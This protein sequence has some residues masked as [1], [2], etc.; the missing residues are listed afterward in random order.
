ML[1]GDGAGHGYRVLRLVSTVTHAWFGGDEPELEDKFRVDRSCCP[2]TLCSPT[3]SIKCLPTGLYIRTLANQKHTRGRFVDVRTAAMS[4][5]NTPGPHNK[6][7]GTRFSHSVPSLLMCVRIVRDRHRCI[8]T[9]SAGPDLAG[10]PPLHPGASLRLPSTLVRPLP[11]YHPPL[12][13]A[14]HDGHHV[15]QVFSQMP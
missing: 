15:R 5:S 1:G 12:H 7:P 11:R 2:N 9:H 3:P 13:I 8:T 4:D 6:T 10:P 14:V